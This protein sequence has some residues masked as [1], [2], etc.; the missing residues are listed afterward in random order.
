MDCKHQIAVP[1]IKIWAMGCNIYK[2]KYIEVT[3]LHNLEDT[4][5][6][7]GYPGLIKISISD[8]C[9]E[10]WFDHPKNED[11]HYF[12]EFYLEYQSLQEEYIFKFLTF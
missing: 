10:S 7:S 5:T 9:H 8:K 3:I 11:T 12:A 1:I 2:C 6:P 4:T